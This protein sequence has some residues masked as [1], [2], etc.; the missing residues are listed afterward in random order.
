MKHLKLHNIDV[1]KLG[2]GTWKLKG[3]ECINAVSSALDMGYRHIDTAQAYDNE[4]FVGEGIRKSNINRDDFFLTTKIFRDQFET[5]SKA[6]ESIHNSLE[7]LQTDYVDLI[8]VHWPFA[9]HSIEEMLKPLMKAQDEG[10]TRLIGV[11]NFTVDQMQ[12][13]KEISDNRVCLNQVEY[14]P[15]LNQDP[16]LDFVR[17][18]DWGMTSY[19]PLGRGTAVDD[20]TIKN[21]SETH[22][23]SSAQIILRWLMQQDNV[24]AIP[25][26]SHVERIAENFSIFDFE[27][28]GDEMQQILDLRSAN[29]RQVDPDFAPK[30]DKAA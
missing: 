28:S 12:Q 20:K 19:S 24:L 26:S 22:N 16:I 14:H 2:L 5:T 30:W 21:I 15:H 11:S 18:N 3:D 6:M 29:D 23:K 9:E 4:E 25:K 10:K 27:L 17:D 8:L 13:A 7:K 1:P